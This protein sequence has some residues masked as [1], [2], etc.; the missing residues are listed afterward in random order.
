MKIKKNSDDWLA[1]FVGTLISYLFIIPVFIFICF[2]FNIEIKK[3]YFIFPLIYTIYEQWKSNQFRAFSTNFTEK[4]NLE[5]L[6][7]V[8]LKLK[9]RH[10]KS[11]TEIKI[12]N[13]KITLFPLD[14][15]FE[16]KSKK[17]YYNFSYINTIKTGRLT[18]FF[19]LA[20]FHKLYFLYVLKK[21]IRK[22]VF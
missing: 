12:R 21:E 14:I 11:Y 22:I 4:K 2:Y 5:I 1:I 13:N 10:Y 9:W 17:I 3:V 15:T 19:G 6:E 16:V 8:F 20:T 18:F 7:K